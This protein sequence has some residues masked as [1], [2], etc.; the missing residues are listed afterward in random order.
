MFAS[1]LQSSL[2]LLSIYTGVLAQRLKDLKELPEEEHYIQEVIS[3]DG[4]EMIICMHPALAQLIHTAQASLHDNTY[5][6]IHDRDWKEWEVV[7]WD[8]RH[9]RRQ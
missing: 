6:C 4:I 8:N 7:I 1:P 2:N 5:K 3:K 9:H